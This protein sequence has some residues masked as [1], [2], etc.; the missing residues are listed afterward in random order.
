MLCY[1]L[2]N[3]K[4]LTNHFEDFWHC[5]RGKKCIHIWNV[6]LCIYPRLWCKKQETRS[7]KQK[8][9]NSRPTRNCYSIDIF[10]HN[11]TSFLFISSFTSVSLSLFS[12]TEKSLQM[13][14]KR[15]FLLFKLRN[16]HGCCSLHCL[17]YIT[18]SH[19][20]SSYQRH[21]HP[22]KPKEIKKRGW[23]DRQKGNFLEKSKMYLK[24]A[25]GRKKSL[26]NDNFS[27][28]NELYQVARLVYENSI[29]FPAWFKPKIERLMLFP[30]KFFESLL[31]SFCFSVFAANAV[32]GGKAKQ[33]Q[34]NAYI[35]FSA[36]QFEN[37]KK[38]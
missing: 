28:W 12:E 3:W 16:H 32:A 35:P 36:Y 8:I 37:G 24:L 25:F 34:L 26:I 19:F 2:R 4:A 22:N 10:S 5:Q 7:K 1:H 30:S 20:P 33:Q 29:N 11:M 14:D 23:N 31:H 21:K 27:Q 15:S 9:Q 17:M 38:L 18:S 13:W 6:F